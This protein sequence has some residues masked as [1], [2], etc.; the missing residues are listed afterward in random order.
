MIE[1]IKVKNCQ[2]GVAAAVSLHG[3]NHVT[4][5][6]SSFLSSEEEISYHMLYKRD[7]TDRLKYDL[8]LGHY[9]DSGPVQVVCDEASC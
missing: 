5:S 8:V 1:T 7:A 2:D 6:C 3:L 4:D 9:A